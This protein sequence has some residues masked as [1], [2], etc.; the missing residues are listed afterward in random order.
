MSQEEKGLGSYLSCYV[1]IIG[2]SRADK[3]TEVGW[4]PASSMGN[5][6][7]WRWWDGKGWSSS[8]YPSSEPTVE[9]IKHAASLWTLEA[10]RK[11]RWWP[12]ERKDAPQ[13]DQYEPVMG[14]VAF[15]FWSY[16]EFPYVRYAAGNRKANN[17]YFVP[18]YQSFVTPLATL[19]VET[20]HVAAKAIEAI[21]S[22]RA[23]EIR[24]A[25][26][27]GREDLLPVFSRL[28]NKDAFMNLLELKS[29]SKRN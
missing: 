18:S 21:V 24:R 28:P 13:P 11:I 7:S 8:I 15:V 9:Q 6:N 2:K 5:M 12:W 23:A 22:K 3:P 14:G 26:T 10:S 20:G 19:D 27:L 4:Y 25:T 16:D 17:Q 29:I 1:R